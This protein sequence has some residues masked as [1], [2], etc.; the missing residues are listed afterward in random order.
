MCLKLTCYN[1]VGNSRSILQHLN[2]LRT[3]LA[4]RPHKLHRCHW[5]E[6]PCRY[7]C[8]CRW[9]QSSIGVLWSDDGCVGYVHHI[10]TGG[11]DGSFGW[12]RLDCDIGFYGVSVCFRCTLELACCVGVGCCGWHCDLCVYVCVVILGK[13][14]E[15]CLSAVFTVETICSSKWKYIFVHLHKNI[16]QS[17][18]I[19]S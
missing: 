3:L 1:Y 4:H 11:D 17:P 9:C 6:H 19:W 8:R 5:L 12:V 14:W 16:V 13:G 15:W 10:A 2:H 18:L 7:P